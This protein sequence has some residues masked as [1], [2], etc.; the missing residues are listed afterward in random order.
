[1]G[2]GEGGRRGAG[3]GGGGRGGE[4]KS[5]GG[6][7]QVVPELGEALHIPNDDW[8]L[9]CVIIGDHKGTPAVADRRRAF[10]LEERNIRRAM[11]SRRLLTHCR[12]VEGQ[13]Y[14]WGGLGGG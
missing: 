11:E 8:A 2:G 1:M 14:L 5:R 4:S 7:G 12:V 13:R 3:R 9:R 10:H 6:Q